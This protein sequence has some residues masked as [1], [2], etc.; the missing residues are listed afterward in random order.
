MGSEMCIRDRL[1]RQYVTI[2][3]KNGK[4][5][6]TFNGTTI[7]AVGGVGEGTAQSER[8]QLL[9][10]IPLLLEVTYKVDTYFTY[11]TDNIGRVR[12][13]TGILQPGP[14][15][16][17]PGQQS[18]AVSEKDGNPRTDNLA[19]SDDG[20]HMIGA[21]F[22]GPVEQINYFA[23]NSAD[24][25][26]GIWKLMENEWKRVAEGTQTPI[27][28]VVVISPVRVEITPNFSGSSKRPFEFDVIYSYNG[29]EE[30]LNNNPNYQSSIAN[31]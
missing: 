11:E 27:N 5:W 21:Q 9:N 8:N 19:T 16:R 10:L 15:R 28:G 20:G 23:Q 18:W 6:D 29:I 12:R 1:R 13:I 17:D 24:S 7:E 26:Y 14:S 22:N 2:L 25:R 31:P 30:T 3:D 4:L